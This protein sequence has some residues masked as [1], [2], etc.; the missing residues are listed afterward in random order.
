MCIPLESKEPGH[1]FGHTFRAFLNGCLAVENDTD[2]DPRDLFI[3]LIAGTLHDIGCLLVQRYEEKNVAI[4]HAEAGAIMVY[5]AWK[6]H[7]VSLTKE[8]ISLVCY[9]I[10]GH[11]YY[12]KDLNV[13]LNDKT[14]VIVKPYIGHFQNGEPMSFFW[15]TR[16]IDRFDTAGPGFIGRHFLTLVESHSDYD[17]KK[18]EF[19][20]VEFEKH[21]KPIM[22]DSTMIKHVDSFAKNQLDSEIVGIFGKGSFARLRD[23]QITFN[24]IIVNAV[25]H[26]KQLSNLEEIEKKW[27]KFLGDKIEPTYLGKKTAAALMEKYKKLPYETRLA[28]NNGFI[29]CMETYEE[30]GDYIKDGL[31]IYPSFFRLGEMYVKGIL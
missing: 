1:G 15:I 10:A 27:E 24:N 2:Y 30:W 23:N 3:G 4:H 28:W 19:F 5:R 12:R 22:D 7:K 25:L 29:V 26:P 17:H 13:S 18:E 8:E 14:P 21:L 20:E 31:K 16:W 9:A 11:V 6:T